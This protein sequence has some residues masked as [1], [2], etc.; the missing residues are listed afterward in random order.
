MKRPEKIDESK[1]GYRAESLME[2]R[3]YNTACDKWEKFLPDDGEVTSIVYCVTQYL[4]LN[5]REVAILNG[6]LVKKISARLRGE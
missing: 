3:G 2:I 4:S 5:D 1:E 6:R